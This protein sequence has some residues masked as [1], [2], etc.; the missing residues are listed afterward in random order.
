MVP[1]G[2]RNSREY[3]DRRGFPDVAVPLHG[4]REEGDVW[5][6]A[7]LGSLTILARGRPAP[8]QEQHWPLTLQSPLAQQ[9]PFTS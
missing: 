4:I 1:G 7:L 5:G 8:R 3:D 2:W 6:A 9:C